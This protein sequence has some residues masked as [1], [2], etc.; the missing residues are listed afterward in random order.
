MLEPL[1][2]LRMVRQPR[3]FERF[4]CTGAECED[5]CCNGWGIPVDRDTYDKYQKL[6]GV[7][8]A[9]RPLNSLV[10]INPAGSSSMDY[11]RM[12]FEGTG[13]AAL[14]DGLCSI[15]Q[16]LGEAYIPD[17]C[18]T[19]P[20]VWNMKGGRIEKSLHLSCPE[21]ARLV[22]TDPDAMA[23][24]DSP[25][26]SPSQ[27]AGSI[28][29]VAGAADERLDQVTI[30]ATEVIKERSVPLWQRIV[31]LGFAVDRMAGVDAT[32]AATILK[33]HLAGLRQGLFRG[34]FADRQA[35]PAYQLETVLELIVARLGKDHTPGRFLEC[36]GEFMGG[37]AWTKESTMEELIDRYR[38][39]SR[40]YFQP[41]MRRNEHL[42][43]N[44]LISYVF[45]TLFPYRRRQ[46]DQTF[47]IDFNKES[48]RNA[49][50]ALSAHYAII[51]TVLVGMAALH[52][53]ELCVEHAVKLVQSYSRAF[54]YSETFE[55]LIIDFLGKNAGYATFGIAALV[56]E[57]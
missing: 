22:L 44:F 13:C 2:N 21:A 18:S 23:F 42:L 30:L 4:H 33:N 47:A 43:E 3:C 15:Q 26:E 40:D 46:P 54:L 19:Y 31:S 50:L 38:Q 20:R 7:R 14:I 24:D 51:R 6:P 8:I 5:T 34:I 48:M 1:P 49:F 39:A 10:V 29:D 45:R 55:P 52:K 32:R 41:F 57:D 25:E 36:Y 11:G 12:L 28:T 37:L 9:G 27:R 56:S 53:N 35:A 16:T 17:L